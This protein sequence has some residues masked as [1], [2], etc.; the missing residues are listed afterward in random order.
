MYLNAKQNICQFEELGQISVRY[1]LFP[2]LIWNWMTS[3]HLTFS[4]FL[5]QRV[6]KLRRER[7]SN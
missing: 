2:V 4:L 6:W 5:G 7:D 1:N 3:E